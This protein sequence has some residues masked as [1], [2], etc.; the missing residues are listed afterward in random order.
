M[1]TSPWIFAA[2]LMLSAAAPAQDLPAA[3]PCPAG[4]AP[5]HQAGYAKVGGLDQW[6]TID[7]GDCRKPIILFI[8]G[9]PG[10]S[11]APFAHHLYANWEHDFTLVQWDQRG[12]GMTFVKTPP[13]ANDVLTVERMRDDG[14]EVAQQ[15]SRRL[16]QAKLILFASSWG[17]VLGLEMAQARP[18]QFHAYVGSAQMVDPRDPAAY[19][20]VL[21]T[22]AELGDTAGLATLQ[23]IG[24]PPWSDPR[25]AGIM[26]RLSRRYEKART[27]PAPDAWWR[28][29]PRYARY[30]EQFEQADDYSYLQFVGL[31]G[32]GMAAG[33]DFNRKPKEYR[34]PLYFIQGAEDLV[35]P[36]AQTRSYVD[37]IKAPK[38][39]FIVLPR[40]GHDPNPAMVE[41]QLRVLKTIAQ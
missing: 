29:D 25:N 19:R 22:A 3:P 7:G 12:A 27:D 30:E 23:K 38:K 31:K 6:V 20:A 18:E 32:N 13:G 40:T 21:K 33:I 2:G 1:R 41:A 4:G 37:S 34:L 11:L 16:G 28:P 24:A 36:L 14:L 9:G 15:V 5:I 39:E 8:H 10:N 35:T 17:S 26:R